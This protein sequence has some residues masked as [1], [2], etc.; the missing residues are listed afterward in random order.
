MIFLCS[1]CDLCLAC[2]SCLV[3]AWLQ[4]VS[5]L[6]TLERPH[7]SLLHV[8]KSLSYSINSH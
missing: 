3:S 1:A 4:A 2:D 5:V 8:L 6:C 7:G